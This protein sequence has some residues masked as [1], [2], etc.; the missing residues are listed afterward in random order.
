M[1]VDKVRGLPPLIC[2]ALLEAQVA[3]YPE[4]ERD[5]EAHHD[6]YNGS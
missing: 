4:P 2:R 1:V 6:G 5:E 3:A